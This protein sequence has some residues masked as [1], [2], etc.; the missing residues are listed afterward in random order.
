M[1]LVDPW[2]LP[3]VLQIYTQRVAMEEKH[4]GE[5]TAYLCCT[6]IVYSHQKRSVKSVERNPLEARVSRALAQNA[7]QRG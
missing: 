1:Y 7:N 3:T 5:R 4:S 6:Y 2:K